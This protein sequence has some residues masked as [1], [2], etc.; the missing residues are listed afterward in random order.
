MAVAEVSKEL[1]QLLTEYRRLTR[2]GAAIDPHAVAEWLRKRVG[3]VAG[4]SRLGAPAEALIAAF[5]ESARNTLLRLDADLREA[6]QKKGWKIDGQWPRFYVERVV[7]LEIDEK[8]HRAVVGE[9]TVRT[10]NVPDLVA[11]VE[12]QVRALLPS[13]FDPKR[14]V[15][16]LADCYDRLAS[17]EQRA[18]SIW[19]LYREVLLAHQ[20]QAFWRSGRPSLFRALSEQ[21]FRACLTALLERGPLRT[22][23][24]RELTLL[25]PLK[26]D[27]GMYLC[28]P[29][30]NRFAFVGRVEFRAFSERGTP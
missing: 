18:V 10:L 30:E 25:P 1:R 7:R 11:A 22:A 21:T 9:T 23:D 13:R 5:E 24:G 15:E 16:A 6:L 14:F 29:A 27:D 3:A 20:P 17:R 4:A 12:Q 26:A 8:E 2:T 19:E 28:H